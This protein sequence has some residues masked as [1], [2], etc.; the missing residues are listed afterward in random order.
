MYRLYRRGRKLLCG[1]LHDFASRGALRRHLYVQPAVLLVRRRRH[2]LAR[3]L[4]EQ[5]LHIPKVMGL[6]EQNLM[7]L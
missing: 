7:V 5:R 2:V 6:R 1:G 4:L 3:L